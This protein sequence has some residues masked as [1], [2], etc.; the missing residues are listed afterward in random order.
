MNTPHYVLGFMFSPCLNEVLFVRKQKPAWQ[1]G[2]MNGPG[3]KIEPGEKPTHAM[4]REFQEETGIATSLHD[5]THYA[6]VS[7]PEFRVECFFAKG[8]V[9]QASSTTSEP[10]CVVRTKD[11][12]PL[13]KWG[14]QNLA[15]LVSL[16]LDSMDGRPDFT[17][18]RYRSND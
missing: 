4:V 10:V 16:A 17:V 9:R 2:F 8:D 12:H 18:A 11:I 5:W 3:G 7:G 13:Q 1:A 6:E 14:I 15:W